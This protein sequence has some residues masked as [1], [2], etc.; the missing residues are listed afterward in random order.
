MVDF[1]LFKKFGVNIVVGAAMEIVRKF[2]NEQLKEVKAGD[3]YRAILENRDL[4]SVTPHGTKS[5]S[6]KFKKTYRSLF[7]KHQAE[8]STELL[9]Q[10]MRE[11]HPDL[12]ST[13]INTNTRDK[14]IGLIWFDEQV[15]RIKQKIIEM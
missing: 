8:I 9:L 10:W 2:L 4:W 15:R 6:L 11:D 12:Y 5:T 7:E 14:K 1:S 3:L 13:I